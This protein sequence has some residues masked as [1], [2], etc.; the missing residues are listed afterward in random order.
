MQTLRTDLITVITSF[1]IVEEEL[2]FKSNQTKQ[3]QLI[4]KSWNSCLQNL[5]DQFVQ[6]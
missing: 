5:C 6:N 2:K 1:V 3:L 4:S